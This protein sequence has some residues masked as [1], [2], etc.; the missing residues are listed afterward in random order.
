M[1]YVSTQYE[2]LSTAFFLFYIEK[3][4]EAVGHDKLKE[5]MWRKFLFLKLRRQ[6]KLFN[7]LT[8]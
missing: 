7:K 1:N 6:K 4:E 5:K 2:T 8:F 3:T